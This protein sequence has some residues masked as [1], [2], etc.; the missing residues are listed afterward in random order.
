MNHILAK[1]TEKM[2]GHTALGP[3]VRSFAGRHEAYNWL[4]TDTEAYFGPFW[5]G[6]RPDGSPKLFTG[7]ELT[8]LSSEF[9]DGQLIWGVLTALPPTLKVDLEALAVEP[10]STSGTTFWEEAP[11]IQYPGAVA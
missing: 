2:P 6:S 3:L 10:V 4:V 9:P 1:A 11:R 7:L 8:R 5:D